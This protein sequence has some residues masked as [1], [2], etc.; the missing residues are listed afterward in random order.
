M[1]CTSKTKVHITFLSLAVDV[2]MCLN[3]CVC[4][5]SVSLDPKSEWSEVKDWDNVP[6][7]PV[8]PVAR[9]SKIKALRKCVRL[10]V[11]V[12]VCE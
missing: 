10:C 1:L 7:S 6:I 3:V 12:C 2:R 8:G 5:L 4:V 9:D 11:C